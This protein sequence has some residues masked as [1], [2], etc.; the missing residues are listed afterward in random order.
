NHIST[1]YR[2]ILPREKN[3]GAISDPQKLTLKNRG[4]KSEGQN[5][6]GS[7]RASEKSPHEGQYLGLQNLT[8]KHET[9][10]F[11]SNEEDLQEPLAQSEPQ[12]LTPLLITDNILTLSERE[13]NLRVREESARQSAAE[14]LVSKFYELLSQQ[15]TT[16]KRQKSISECIR[17]LEEGFTE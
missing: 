12:N 1:T 8:G 6:R 9:N 13:G 16:T 3:G 17:L 15:P 5:L 4:A 2:I 14:V 11:S 7:N 10:T